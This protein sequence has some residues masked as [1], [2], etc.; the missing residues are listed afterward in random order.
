MPRTRHQKHNENLESMRK[1]IIHND[2]QTA[3][4]LF[5][6]GFKLYSEKSKNNHINLEDSNFLIFNIIRLKR[7]SFL[8]LLI[9]YGLDVNYILEISSKIYVT[10]LLYSSANMW[11]EGVKLLLEKGALI[12]FNQ[13]LYHKLNLNQNF[14]YTPFLNCVKNDFICI[15]ILYLLLKHC[16]INR[17]NIDL[18]YLF[19]ECMNLY[20][21]LHFRNQ[22]INRELSSQLLTLIYTWN[23]VLS[24]KNNNKLNT[25]NYTNKFKETHTK[26]SDIETFRLLINYCSPIILQEIIKDHIIFIKNSELT[27][28]FKFYQN[29]TDKYDTKKKKSLYYNNLVLIK[30]SYIKWSPLKHS[31]YPKSYRTII[32]NLMSIIN[33]LNKL[34]NKK[35]LPFLPR[36]LWFSI[37]EFL[38]RHDFD[39]Q[40]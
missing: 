32:S 1:S 27:L 19:D 31:L 17:I 26:F 38:L 34:N 21:Y 28:F 2:I 9:R 16:Y 30:N 37:I 6:S 7:L 35:Q 14:K 24:D 25:V 12:E 3:Q 4:E 11:Y 29:I 36:E 13:D 22:Y 33:R 18:N 20:N 15:K 8:K 39:S 40:I 23:R 10:P 5:E